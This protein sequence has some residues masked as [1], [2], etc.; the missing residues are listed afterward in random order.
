M[1]I[2]EGLVIGFLSWVLAI[3]LTLPISY[4]MAYGLGVVLI[5]SPLPLALSPSGFIIC[6]FATLAVSA[7]SCLWPAYSTAKLSVRATLLY[8]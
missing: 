7:L 5:Q 6:L 2:G 3:V 8:E 4:G 1:I